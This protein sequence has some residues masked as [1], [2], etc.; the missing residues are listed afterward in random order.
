MGVV[1]DPFKVDT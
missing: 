1:N